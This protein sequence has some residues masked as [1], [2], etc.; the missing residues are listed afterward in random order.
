MAPST[1]PTSPAFSADTVLGRESLINA[2]LIGLGVGVVG[3][4]LTIAFTNFIMEPIFCRSADT[5]TV[6]DNGAAISWGVAH[7][8]AAVASVLALVR[9]NVY[10]PLLV[11]LAALIAL[12]GLSAWLAPLAWY[13]Q[14]LWQAVLF[15]LAYGLF[16]WLAALE[17]FT[18]SIVATIVVVVLIRLLGAL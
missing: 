10:R 15:A 2:G 6:C 7:V 8:V 1:T 3:W 4:L 16:A 18:L 11:V 9:T 17:R 14:L 5:F 13:W 12:W